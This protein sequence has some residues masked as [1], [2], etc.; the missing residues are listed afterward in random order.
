M[1]RVIFVIT[2]L[3]GSFHLTG[4]AGKHLSTEEV[5]QFTIAS[6]TRQTVENVLGKPWETR[7]SISD[8]ELIKSLKKFL[9]VNEYTHKLAIYTFSFSP[10]LLHEYAFFELN[11]FV[12][13]HKD[14]LIDIMEYKCYSQDSC[15]DIMVAEI[16]KYTVDDLE[17]VRKQLDTIKTKAK[18][19]QQAEIKKKHE[20]AKREREKRLARAQAA[21]V[22]KKDS[23]SGNV[24]IKREQINDAQSAPAADKNTDKNK[25]SEKQTQVKKRK[26]TL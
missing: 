7:L 15:E 17:A 22:E 11:M 13:D 9:D 14:V 16:S 2:L 4:C 6:D 26:I 25:S 12:Y 18:K 5:H 3:L 8:A 1:N 10:L 24:T 20:Q 19:Q 23:K 21:K